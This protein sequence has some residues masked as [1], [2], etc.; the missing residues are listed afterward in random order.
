MTWACFCS[1]CGSPWLRRHSGPA[2]ASSH[3]GSIR[4]TQRANSCEV[5]TSSAAITQGGGLRASA[6]DGWIA[7]RVWR[8]PM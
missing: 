5:S 7:N 6:D 2:A 8:A 1:Q 3:A 4:A